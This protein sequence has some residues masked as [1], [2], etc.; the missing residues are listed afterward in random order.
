MKT[1]QRGLVGPTVSPDATTLQVAVGDTLRRATA[2]LERH[3][4]AG[5]K[6]L[7]EGIL[8]VEPANAEALHLLGIAY[9]QGGDAR[10]AEP[11]IARSL[12]LRLK[13]AWSLA[14][15]GAVLI[16]LGRYEEALI[17]LDQALMLDA[18]HAPSMIER[19]K[20]LLALER[21]SE[22]LTSYDRAL[23]VVADRVDA[24]N[25]RGQAL[26]G[27]KR[28]ADALISFDRVL[29]SEKGN[30]MAL[31]H[32]GHA[33][34]DLGRRE[35]ALR[36]YR[37]ALVIQPK[38][39]DL[40]HLC[41]AVLI[42]LGRNAEALA[43]AD[44]GLAVQPRD[45]RLLYQSCVALDLLHLY[46]ELL[47]RCDRLLEVS[48]QHAGAWF[49]RGNGFQGLSRYEEAAEAYGTAISLAPGLT[50]ALRNQAASF[51][52]LGRYVEALDNYDR[53][54]GNTGPDTMLLHNRAIVL[55]QLGRYDE[56]LASY[57][58]A[59]LAPA[60][61]TESRITRAVV[62]QQ[63]RRDDEA[64][65]CY[66]QARMIDPK[67]ADA[68]RSEAFCRLLMGDYVEGWKQHEGRW[69]AS[70][71]MLRRRHAD[72]PLWL[73]AESVAGKMVLIHAEQGYGDTLQFCRYASLL[74][75]RGATVV[76]EVPATLK[77]LLES[78][79][80]VSRVVAVGDPLPAFDFHCPIM[81]LPLAFGT[82]LATIPAQTPYLFVDPLQRQEWVRRLD[83]V[84]DRGCLRI[85]LTWSG[86]A[87]QNNDENRSISLAA[88]APIYELD[89]T[90]VSLQ[91]F[92]RERDANMLSQS[93]IVDFG[94]EL[95]SFA[96]T[97]ALIEALDLVISVDTSV[98]HL[99]GALGRPL[100][101]LLTHVADWRWLLDRADSP[102]YPGARLF[103]QE[104]PGDWSGLI[105]RVAHALPQWIGEKK[106]AT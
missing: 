94:T 92:V 3:D 80:G 104:K 23:G 58:A 41:C 29:L 77:A 10:R 2:L 79:P 15:H 1:Q 43:C 49:G 86:N 105:E 51:R 66:E 65:A 74:E 25:G 9:F 64:L 59:A 99:A 40:L 17:P 62:L 87:R 42:D 34:R 46:D 103:R 7:Y 56:A 54:L 22:A 21:Y 30:G 36:C 45:Q 101:V 57:E 60:E 13:R 98:A 6:R 52:M 106:G 27:L 81:S 61:T 68:Q 83:R 76:L 31:V 67:H 55:Q 20:A 89:A 69:L 82:T 90:F 100:W 26:L 4:I 14:N 44:E 48:P 91:P 93:G 19:G 50:E 11:L 35:E 16:A 24:W 102:W 32:R 97:A 5:A 72:R 38:S 84:V 63:L 75:A 47:K 8:L 78:L 39:L 37:L 73:G 85:G 12:A 28:P 33:L 95:T 18:K 70:D 53:A 96:D 88:L 71:V